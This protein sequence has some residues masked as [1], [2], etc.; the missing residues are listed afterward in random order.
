MKTPPKLGGQKLTLV[1]FFLSFLTYVLPLILS[2]FFVP[3][4]VYVYLFNKNIYI[5]LCSSVV[6][7]LHM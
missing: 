7:N 5:L 4:Q 6:L 1:F 3:D 2:L